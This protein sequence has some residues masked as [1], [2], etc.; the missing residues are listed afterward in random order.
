MKA[1]AVFFVFVGLLAIFAVDSSRRDFASKENVNAIALN[2]VEYRNAVN[3]YALENKSITEANQA[4]LGL[5]SGWVAL[6]TWENRI[7]GHRCYV[8]GPASADE[9]AAA[10]SLLRGSYAVGWKSASG[11]LEPRFEAGTPIS[12]PGW[13]PVDSVVSV[14]S[15]D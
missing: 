5:P 3:Q 11:V 9:A 14:I 4:D 13:I 2:F 8:F 7:E 10:R 15:L 6:K 12:L 1:M